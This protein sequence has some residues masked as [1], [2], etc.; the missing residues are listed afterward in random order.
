MNGLLIILSVLSFAS[1]SLLTRTFQTKLQKAKH[2]INLYQAFFTLVASVAYFT[3]AFVQGVSFSLHMLLPA[4][5]FGI[6]FSLAVLF[7]AECME[8]G[9]M[10]LTSVITN[11]SLILPVA[12]SWIVLREKIEFIAVAGLLLIIVT[13]VLSSL[14][15]KKSEGGSKA[16]WLVFVSIA[17]LANGGSAIVQKQYAFSYGENDLMMLM[18]LAYLTS[19]LIFAIT[20][21]KRNTDAK[22]P[23]NEQI[24]KPL[25]LPLLSVFSGL[26]SFAGNGLLGYLCDKVD[27]GILYPCIN[28]GLCIAVSIASFLLFKE[29][30]TVR[31]LSAICTGVAA[32]ILLNL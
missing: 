28:G 5:L 22:I 21:I 1:N 4:A 32:I 11:L 19:S 7:S 10:S 9:Y 17:F 24:K 2:S 25:L 16:K 27:G 15:T 23:F 20:Y 3:L 26:G 14:T 8:M 30:P 12:F 6:C 18:C 13:L 29:K 31:K